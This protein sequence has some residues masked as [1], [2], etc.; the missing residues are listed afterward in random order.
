MREKT[1]WI[2]GGLAGVLVLAVV[3]LFLLSDTAGEAAELAAEGGE[4]QLREPLRPIR[5]TERVLLVALDGIGDEGLREAIRSGR[6]PHIAALLGAQLDEDVFEHAYATPGALSILPSTT[7]A[8]WASVFTGRPAAETGV[9]GNEW[10][11]REEMRFYAPGP[12]SV[13]EKEHTIKMYTE[14]L[15]GQAIQVPTLFERLDLRAHV[16]MM[17]VFRGADVLSVPAVS[18]VAE[19]FGA[20]ASGLVDDAPVEREPYQAM[21]EMA[22]ERVLEGIRRHGLPDLQVVYIAGVDL[23]THLADP[24]MPEQHR[25][26]QEI[27]DPLVGRVLAAY[28]EQG[29][30]EQTYVIFVSDHG[31]T[32]VLKDERHA[33]ATDMERDPPALI[34]RAGFRMRP[35]VLDPGE[36]D[37]D[38]Q[39]VVAYQGAIAYIYLADRSTCPSRGDRCD[40][41][42]PPRLEEDVLALVRAF[43]EV[44]RTGHPVPDLQGTLDLIFAREP[45]PPEQPALPFQVWDGS[46]LVPVGEYL[47]RHP[48]PDLLRLEERLEGLA[49]GPYGHRAGDLLLLARSGMNRPIQDRFY[50]SHLYNSWH[51]SPETQDSRIPL[52]VA[53]QGTPGQELQR[54][55]SAVVSDPPSQLDVV[56]L[57]EALLRGQ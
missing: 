30:L 57:V 46:R 50:F 20:L 19:L 55:V 31:H 49:A 35:F 5:G 36:G 53:R 21:D 27:V 26:I 38:Y 8:A 13:E 34:E 1:L 12:V 40:W 7:M 24:P 2:V 41:R 18:D 10:Y 11:V 42:R 51:G 32:P 48:R 47:A 17:P 4:I 28:A 15:V 44:N 29:A 43:D 54:R 3:A 39:A 14:G 6:A 33:L 25:Y 22:V 45:R 9:P 56:P 23:Y 52:L 37:Q 16:S